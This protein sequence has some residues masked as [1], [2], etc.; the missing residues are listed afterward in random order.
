MK[1]KLF[2]TDGIRTRAGVFPLN[3]SAI[4]AIGQAI[5]EE[6]CGPILVGEDTRLSSPWIL[7]LLIEGIDRSGKSSVEPAGVIPTPA[8]ALL[9]RSHSFAGGVM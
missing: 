3:A 7:G 8:V 2:G 6:L 5:G 9:T 1:L 4:P